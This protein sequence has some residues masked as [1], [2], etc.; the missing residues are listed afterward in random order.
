MKQLTILIGILLASAVPARADSLDSFWDAI[1]LTISHPRLAGVTVPITLQAAKGE[2][3]LTKLA[4][5]IGTQSIPVPDDELR[6][7]QGPNWR[8]MKFDYL[9]DVKSQAFFVSVEA[10]QRPQPPTSSQAPH[11]IPSTRNTQET[12]EVIYFHFA[13]ARYSR[14][15]RWK[16]IPPSVVGDSFEPTRGIEYEISWPH[17]YRRWVQAASYKT[18]WAMGVA[19]EFVYRTTLGERY[20][21][22]ATWGGPAVDSFGRDREGVFQRDR[23]GV[24][25]V[26][27][28]GKEGH[29]D[30][31]VEVRLR[32]TPG[33]DLA[34]IPAKDVRQPEKSTPPW[35]EPSFRFPPA[36]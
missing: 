33:G 8:S 14:K 21:L 32:A 15:E 16:T 27:F 9:G 17:L 7:V 34:W 25:Q 18:N 23:E 31:V 11:V 20:N 6:D 1:S 24:F 35:P 12:W 19:N 28:P 2:G 3:R 22:P 4:V 30:L 5:T 36:K 10:L 26:G 29:G 13:G